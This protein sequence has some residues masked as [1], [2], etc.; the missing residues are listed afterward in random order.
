MAELQV[1]VFGGT[2][3][4]IHVGHLVFAESL[5]ECL[6]LDRVLLVPSGVPPHKSARELASP[7]HRYAMVALAAAG[8]PAFQVSPV[9]VERATPAY[10]VETLERL[11]AEWAG[12]RLWFLMGSD[13]F[14]D[15]PTWRR[16]ERLATFATLAVG[17]R[18]GGAFDPHG[19]ASRAVL[20]RLGRGRWRRVPP[21]S[22]DALAPGEVA[23]AEACSVPVSARD[24]RARL[25]AGRSVRYL[26]PPAVADYIDQHRLYAAE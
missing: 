4:P 15:L 6:G 17:A 14:L 23:L 3:N 13:T 8:H 24:L 20:E 25:V 21:E 5:R 1:G 18:A 22:P 16:P 9:E 2:F 26:V 7:L 11:A 10:S 12:S 19:P